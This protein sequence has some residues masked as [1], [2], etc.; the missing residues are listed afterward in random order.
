MRHTRICED[1]SVTRPGCTRRKA[2]GGECDL[3]PIETLQLVVEDADNLTFSIAGEVLTLMSRSGV[4]CPCVWP[5][6]HMASRKWSC[7]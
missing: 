2:V 1:C 3:P 6:A 4:G 5:D 7:S